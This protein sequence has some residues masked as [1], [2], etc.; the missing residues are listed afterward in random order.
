MPVA[1]VM[2]G[3]PT[4]VGAAWSSSSVLRATVAGLPTWSLTWAVTVT[5]PLAKAL[6]SALWAG[7]SDQT[8]PLTVAVLLRVLGVLALSVKVTVTVC[9]SCAPTVVPLML[10]CV[11]SA[12]LIWLSPACKASMAMVGATVSTSTALLCAVEVVAAP[13]TVLS[14]CTSM[15]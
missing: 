7:V 1:L 2:A 14:S 4:T 9:P 8:P 13:L 10:T 12:R 6:R 5:L 11:D 15:R 3:L